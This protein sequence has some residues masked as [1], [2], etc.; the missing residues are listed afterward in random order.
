MA[1]E[2]IFWAEL[3]RKTVFPVSTEWSG[4][5]LRERADGQGCLGDTWTVSPPGTRRTSQD[6]LTSSTGEKGVRWR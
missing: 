1:A 5:R 2:R 4:K 6:S 3:L